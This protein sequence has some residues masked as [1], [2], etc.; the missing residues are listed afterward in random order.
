MKRQHEKCWKVLRKLEFVI[1]NETFYVD[2]RTPCLKK[3]LS[4]SKSNAKKGSFFSGLT[5]DI[6]ESSSNLICLKA[7]VEEE[8][9]G[10]LVC[11]FCNCFLPL[12]YILTLLFQQ[13]L[14]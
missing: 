10:P 12:L 2:F 6:F 13:I 8:C 5:E 7:Q 9:K 4:G 1:A 11:H 3:S 14:I